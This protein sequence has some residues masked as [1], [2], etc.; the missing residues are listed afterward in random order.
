[1]GTSSHSVIITIYLMLIFQSTPSLSF[2][3][4]DNARDCQ[5]LT[6]IPSCTDVNATKGLQCLLGIPIY[7]SKFYPSGLTDPA[8]ASVGHSLA[9]DDEGLTTVVSAPYEGKGSVFIYSRDTQNDKWAPI[10]KIPPSNDAIIG[11]G[12]EAAISG[13]GNTIALAANLADNSGDV[14]YTFNRALGGS[15]WPGDTTAITAQDT[16]SDLKLSKDGTIMVVGGYHGRSSIY[17]RSGSLVSGFSWSFTANL[18]VTIPTDTQT[19]Y[20][21]VAI[22]AGA[23]RIA[24]VYSDALFVFSRSGATWPF[25]RIST[26][27]P[28][29]DSTSQT[30]AMSSDGNIIAVCS[31]IISGGLANYCTI[32]I[33]NQPTNTWQSSPSSI[34]V[35]EELSFKHLGDRYLAM[36]GDGSIIVSNDFSNTPSL[37]FA[38][39]MFT[40]SSPTKWSQLVKFVAEP[41]TQLGFV[42]DMA[43][44]RNGKHLVIGAVSDGSVTFYKNV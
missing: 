43:M 36:S 41:G 6:D 3:E 14:I 13:D 24:I 19:D 2:F 18:T 26:K 32:Y 30:V 22:S 17:T 7:N 12:C 4:V 10:S 28:G 29:I 16:I 33:Y 34:T 21:S 20:N 23:E 25:V 31:Q 5:G 40:R 8:A 9:M 37:T 44:S 35:N 39:F 1:M 11:F 27:T 15:S 38:S 42:G